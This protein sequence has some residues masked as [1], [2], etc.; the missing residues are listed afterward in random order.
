MI[1]RSGTR[2]AVGMA[3]ALIY[4]PLSTGQPARAGNRGSKIVRAWHPDATS[5]WTQVNQGPV[6]MMVHAAVRELTGIGHT[7]M[8]WASL[9]PGL[10]VDETVGIEEQ[11]Q[12]IA[13]LRTALFG[14]L[15]PD[16]HVRGCPQRENSD[17]PHNL[18]C[19]VVRVAL[20]DSE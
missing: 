18:R 16:G 15:M 1:Q 6:D 14:E 4:T 3:L 19:T 11:T 13:Q 9:F 7:A 20:R 10:T 8:A 12:Q 2:L 17:A 5:G